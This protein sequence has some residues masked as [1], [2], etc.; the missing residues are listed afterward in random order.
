MNKGQVLEDKVYQDLKQRGFYQEVAENVL[1]NDKKGCGREIDEIAI[2]H[3]TKTKNYILIVEC[4]L[5]DRR[6]KAVKQLIYAREYARRKYPNSRVFCFYAH[7]WKPC[8]KEY[9]ME[10]ITSEELNREKSRH[11]I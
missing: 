10:W 7:N 2:H 11:S 6:T 8:T 3:S 9:T 5:S 1:F 4:K